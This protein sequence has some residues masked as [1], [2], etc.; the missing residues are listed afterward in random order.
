MAAARKNKRNKRSGS[1]RP[2][3]TTGDR[4]SG[5]GEPADTAGAS[6]KA[7]RADTPGDAGSAGTGGSAA[8]RGARRDIRPYIYAGFDAAMA[9]LYVVFFLRVLPSNHG[10]SQVLAYGTVVA[11]GAMAAGMLIRN[12]WGW[13]IAVAGCATLLLLAITLLVLFLISAAFLA[14]VYGA[15]GQAASLVTFVAGAMTI[16]FIAML[17]AFQMKFLMTRAGRRHFG[18]V[19]LWR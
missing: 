1:R 13:R 19:P 11:A 10:S 17:P 2:Q 3:G 9:A 5:A 8:T 6:E 16:Q 18:R 12:K 14:G 7:G 4:P 15:F